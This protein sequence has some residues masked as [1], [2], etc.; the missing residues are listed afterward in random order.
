M[1]YETYFNSLAD[2]VSQDLIGKNY[3]QLTY[4]QADYV[5]DFIGKQFLDLLDNNLI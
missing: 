2:A 5:N 3:G 1:N 4:E